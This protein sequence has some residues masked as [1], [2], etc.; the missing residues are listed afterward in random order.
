MN[1]GTIPA[2]GK[3]NGGREALLHSGSVARA[4]LAPPARVT[5][6]DA[7]TAARLRRASAEAPEMALLLLIDTAFARGPAVWWLATL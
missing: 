3:E 2:A 7:G 6:E 5:V 4:A 1:E